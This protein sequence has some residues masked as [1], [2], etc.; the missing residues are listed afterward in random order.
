[1]ETYK[2]WR[3]KLKD[4]INNWKI[5]KFYS[6]SLPLAK[7]T[8]PTVYFMC[9]GHRHH[10]GLGDRLEGLVSTYA[11]CRE[12]GLNFKAHWVHPYRLDT[13]LIPN[14]VEWI[15]DDNEISYN[16]RSSRGKWI[17]ETLSTRRNRNKAEKEIRLHNLK[18]L[19][20]YTPFRYTEVNNFKYYF[21][22]LFKP[23]P[24][25][26]TALDEQLQRLPKEYVSVTFRFQQLLGDFKEGKFPTVDESKKDKLIKDCTAYIEYIHTLHPNSTVLVTSDSS[27][28]LEVAKKFHYVYTIPGKVIHLDFN[29]TGIDNQIH[30]KSFL[31]LLLL[32]NAKII[33]SVHHAPLYFSGFPTLAAKIY[34]H[35]YEVL[36]PQ[37][38]STSIEE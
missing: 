9:D 10:G 12:H 25:L 4:V 22:E 5:K 15:T 20:I 11:F 7:N 19:H 2:R 8:T 1:M 37:I 17:S 3:R 31:D 24:Y 34:G 6:A 30:L 38:I 35:E 16:P 23:S 28:F 33:Y 36:T 18:Q 21:E 14:K 32:A 13:F 27:T 26:Q 29:G